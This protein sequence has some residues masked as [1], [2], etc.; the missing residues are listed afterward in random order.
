MENMVNPNFWNNRRV[1]ITGHTGFKGSWLTFWLLDLN[2]QVSGFAQEN[3]TEPTLFQLLDLQSSI[4]HQLGDVNDFQSIKRW[5]RKVEP[6]V[7]FHLA[8]QPIV[9]R[10]YSEPLLTWQTNVLGTLNLLEVVR[11]LKKPCSVVAITTDKVYHNR[12]WPHAYREADRIG[13]HDP[14]SSSKA[15][16]ELAVSSWR[17]SFFDQPSG[18]RV[19]TARAGN[20]IGG[21]DWSADR[22]VPDLVRSLYANK[23]IGVRNPKAIRPWQHV[24]EPLSGYLQL[25]EKLH[26]DNDQTY[27]DAFN[28]GPEASDI[29]SVQELVET[30]L[31]YWSGSWQDQS[32]TN[33]PHESQIL[34]LTIEKARQLLKWQPCW[35][36]EQAVSK[37]ISWYKE[38][39]QEN[40]CAKQVCSKQLKDFLRK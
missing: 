14:Y 29:R 35:N 20:V 3:E 13:G 16:C 26:Q 17:A 30:S 37:T 4:S 15:A 11:L 5:L 21:G 23:T 7:I 9:R 34:S 8:A 27:Q 28:F 31:Q 38:V 1:A 12:N 19:A 32:D 36:F 39:M 6:E 22:I 24:L 2:A 10:S 40:H 25:A 33:A 18:I